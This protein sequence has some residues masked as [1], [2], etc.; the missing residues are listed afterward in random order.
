MEQALRRKKF[1][2]EG[3]V[4]LRLELRIELDVGAPVRRSRQLLIVKQQKSES[5]E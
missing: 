1:H 3:F 2:F 4:P 5:P